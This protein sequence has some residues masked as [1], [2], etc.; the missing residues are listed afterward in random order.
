MLFTDQMGREIQLTHP[1]RRIISLVP[2]QTELLY[3]LGLRA[4][5][6]GITKFC[7]HPSLWYREKKRVGGTKQYDLKAIAALQPDLIIGNKEEN[8]QEQIEQLMELYPVWM[9]DI[10]TLA[11]AL[12]MIR[13]IGALVNR[14]TEANLLGD[15]IQNGFQKLPKGA[16]IKVVYLIWNQPIM[17]VGVDTFIDDILGLCGFVNL[18]SSHSRYPSLTREE[19]RTLAPEVLLLSSEPFPFKQQHI[20]YFQALLPSTRIILVDGEAFSW[21]GSRLLKTIPYLIEL[22]QNI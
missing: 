1:P 7:I 3:N 17:G 8:S 15:Q 21:Y 5:V 13:S 4:E 6:V 19:L 12:S 18:L 11:D 10:Y 14:Q 9:S 16:P 20:Q 2:S 22:T